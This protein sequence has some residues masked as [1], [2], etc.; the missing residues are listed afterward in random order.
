MDSY[1]ELEKTLLLLCADLAIIIGAA[2]VFAHY[3]AHDFFLRDSELLENAHRLAGV[4]GVVLNGR[5]DMCTPPRTAW[6]LHK[7][8]PGSEFRIAPA[9]LHDT[10]GDFPNGEHAHEMGI[11]TGCLELAHHVWFGPPPARLRHHIGVQQVAHR[12]ISRPRSFDRSSSKSS[13][14]GPPNR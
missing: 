6:E 3:D 2:R 5:F 13:T 1:L 11:R 9:A 4:P 10:F 7:A 8:W 14:L 12:S